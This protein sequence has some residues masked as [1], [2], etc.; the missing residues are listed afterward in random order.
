[1]S[2]EPLDDLAAELFRAARDERPS[3]ETKRRSVAHLT[4]LQRRSQARHRA[5]LGAAVAVFAVAAGLGVFFASSRP[6]REEPLGVRA[7][8]TRP[9]P[10]STAAQLPSTPVSAPSIAPPIVTAPRSVPRPA[11]STTAER[12]GLVDEV[13]RLEK[14]RSEIRSG[15]PTAAL[16]TLD[17]YARDMRGGAMTSEATLLRIEALSRA[18][19]ASEADALARQ[20]VAA[21]PHSSL[22]DRARGFFSRDSARTTTNPETNDD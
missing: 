21:N 22:S 4:N 8:P 5:R 13:R 6:N 1:M 19:R 2:G 9:N 18:G 10:E 15:D 14:A 16:R 7:E 11:P 3:Q 17:G 12:P 20:F